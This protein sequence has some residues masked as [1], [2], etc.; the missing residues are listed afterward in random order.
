[1]AGREALT[2]LEIA[3]IACDIET[4]GIDFYRAAA[5]AVD[6][7]AL[8]D[9]FREL[10]QQEFDHLNTFRDIYKELDERMGGAESTAEYLFDDA[11][12]SYLRSVSQGNVFPDGNDA[13]TWLSKQPG[14][15]DILS[16]A[17]GAE[18]NS[19]LLYAEMASHTSFSYSRRM[20]NQIIKEEQSHIVRLTRQLNDLQ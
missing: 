6:E 3:R 11:L 18:K 17:L 1:M 14:A 10:A 7:K 15:R 16:V 9:L 13:D 4:D 12:T 8:Q 5:A 2:A 20:L 19:I